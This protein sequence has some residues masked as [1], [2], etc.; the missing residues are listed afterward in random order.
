[1]TIPKANHQNTGPSLNHQLMNSL[2]GAGKPYPQST[3]DSHSENS[4]AKKIKKLESLLELYGKL[5]RQSGQAASIGQMKG[6]NANTFFQHYYFQNRPVLIR[7]SMEDWPALRKWSPD[8]FAAN[9]GEVPVEITR[10]REKDPDYEINF[11][12]SLTTLSFK[13]FVDI[14][15]NNPEGN[16][17]YLVARNY[18]FA[19]PSLSSLLDD[20]RPPKEIIDTSVTGIRNSK[21]WFGPGGTVTPLHHDKQ[22]ILFCQVYGRKQFKLIP[23]FELPGMYNHTRYYSEVD[24]ERVDPARFP[25]YPKD[26]VMDLIVHPGEMLLIPAGWWH[27]VKSLDISI[28]VTLSHFNIPGHNTIWECD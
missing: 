3:S 15:T 17:L 11:K 2:T 5:Y 25:Q 21:L 23:S 16:D 20:I 6:I 10:G 24:P 12:K 4:L 7:S 13:E 14:I 8:F 26:A 1:M 18:F 28:S 27:W 22:S 19:N 9:Y